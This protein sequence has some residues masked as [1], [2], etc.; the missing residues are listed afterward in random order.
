MQVL[1]FGFPFSLVMFL[2]LWWLLLL[3]LL[4][5][6]LK[7]LLNARWCLYG[8]HVLDLVGL[9]LAPCLLD[10]D[11]QLQLDL[12]GDRAPLL[13]GLRLNLGLDLGGDMMRQGGEQLHRLLEA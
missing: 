1:V 5:Q 7:L 2:L 13:L 3:L 8:H 6:S 9:D 12:L 11:G 4:L 10:L